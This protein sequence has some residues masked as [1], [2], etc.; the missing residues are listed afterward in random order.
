MKLLN[1]KFFIN[2]KS[3][4]NKIIRTWGSSVM[5]HLGRQGEQ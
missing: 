2:K 4:S 3:F 5:L 1:K